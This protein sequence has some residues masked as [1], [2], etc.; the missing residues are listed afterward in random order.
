MRTVLLVED[1]AQV[2]EVVRRMLERTGFAVITAEDAQQALRIQAEYPGRIEILLTDV[3]LP[4]MSGAQL[5]EEMNVRRIGIRTL[6]MSG[7]PDEV[8]MKHLSGISASSILMKPFEWKQL[9]HSL[10]NLFADLELSHG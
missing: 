10:R 5:A 9:A 1:Q 6:F 4:G 7:Y 3:V 8:L 2:R